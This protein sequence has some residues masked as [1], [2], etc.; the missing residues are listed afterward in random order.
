MQQVCLQ[1]KIGHC[2]ALFNI[3]D[4]VERVGAVPEGMRFG[5][6]VRITHHDSH[7]ELTEYGVDFGFVV[8]RCYAAQLQLAEEPPPYRRAAHSGG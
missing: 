1:T 6:I 3:G 2:M 8:A 7:E 5:R 4:Y